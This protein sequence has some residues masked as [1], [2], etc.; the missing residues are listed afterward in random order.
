MRDQIVISTNNEAISEKAMLQ[1]WN[2]GELRQNGMKYESAAAGE[3]RTSCAA[4]NK[5]GSY[6]YRSVKKNN[7]PK[8]NNDKKK[9]NR[10]GLLF[11]PNHVI[12]NV[13]Q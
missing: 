8:K 1:N 3:E 7:S 2:L 11:K 12:K 5:L 4:I 13:Q 10:C 9:C 6:S